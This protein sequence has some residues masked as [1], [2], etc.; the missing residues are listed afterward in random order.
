MERFAYDAG[1]KVVVLMEEAYFQEFVAIDL[2]DAPDIGVTV[3][4]EAAEVTIDLKSTARTYYFDE[5]S[6]EQGPI[7]VSYLLI[8]PTR[9][10]LVSQIVGIAGIAPSDE[11]QPGPV[12]TF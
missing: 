5:E 3:D 4:W 8:D 11:K 12:L 9:T 10:N 6:C 1:T 7:E 2:S